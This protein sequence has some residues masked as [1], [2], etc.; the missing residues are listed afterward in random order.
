MWSLGNESSYGVN[1]K[2]MS[3]LTRSYNDGRLV[4]YEC[5]GWP[6]ADNPDTVDVCSKMYVQLQ[7]LENEGKSDEKRR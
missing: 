7:E 2:A 1:H 5:A 4:H 6:G 3:E